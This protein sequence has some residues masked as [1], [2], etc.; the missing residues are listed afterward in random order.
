MSFRRIFAH[1]QDARSREGGKGYFGDFC[2]VLAGVGESSIFN[3]VP[4][5]R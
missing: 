2:G 4:P 3:S 1:D 5:E